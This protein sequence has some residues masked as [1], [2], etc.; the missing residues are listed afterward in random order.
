M[1]TFT[2]SVKKRVFE[3]VKNNDYDEYK[4]ICNEA[5]NSSVL[6]KI[7]V[8]YGSLT[9]FQRNASIYYDEYI[10]YTGGCTI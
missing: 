2:N 7:R 8:C 4:N 5:E 6:E 3:V 1:K 10:K 9:G